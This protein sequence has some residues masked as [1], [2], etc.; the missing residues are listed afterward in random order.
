M[1][2]RPDTISKLDELKSEAKF[3]EEDF[4]PGAPT[5]EIRTRCED[6]VNTFLDEV[7]RLLD[8]AADEAAL[9]ALSAELEESFEDEDTEEREKVGDYIYEVLRILEIDAK[10]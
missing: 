4:Y 1:K 7:R 5:D 3:V 6:R 10:Q 2:I 9:V 8:G